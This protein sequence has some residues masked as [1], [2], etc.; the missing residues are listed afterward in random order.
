MKTTQIDKEK[1]CGKCRIV[2]DI[3]AFP[4]LSKKSKSYKQ[5]KN[6]IK[7]WCK[8][9]YKEYSTK[10]M[11]KA[12]SISGSRYDH[13]QRKYGISH[14]EVKIMLKE[15]NYKCDICNKESDHRYDKLCVDHDHKT[16]DVRGMLCF[17]CNVMIGQGKDN[18]ELF[19][20]AIQY[21]KKSKRKKGKK[22]ES[23]SLR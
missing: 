23:I 3:D 19:K 5:F 13:Y 21:I 2:K 6:G 1:Q 8:D 17:S 9:C 11:R 16:G 10:Y 15:R 14:D 7:P 20:N 18:I 4:K 22:D 12:R